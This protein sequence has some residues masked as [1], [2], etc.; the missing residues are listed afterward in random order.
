M[1]N[2]PEQVVKQEIVLIDEVRLLHLKFFEILFLIF[3]IFLEKN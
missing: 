1:K 2:E 3:T